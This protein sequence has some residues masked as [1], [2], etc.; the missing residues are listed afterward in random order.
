[1]LNYVSLNLAKQYN[2]IYDVF[3]AEHN[4]MLRYSTLRYI[5]FEALETE[6]CGKVTIRYAS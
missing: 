2:L 4:A 1:M 3:V 6:T 5:I